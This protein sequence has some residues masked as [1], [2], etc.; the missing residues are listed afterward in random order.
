VLKDYKRALY[1]ANARLDI[2]T[3]L[4]GQK[5]KRAIDARIYLGNVYGHA[6]E[7]DRAL[8]VFFGIAKDIENTPE[9]N[10]YKLV[11]I[12]DKTTFLYE[13]KFDFSAALTWYKKSLNA[14]SDLGTIRARLDEEN[15]ERYFPFY[16]Y[17]YEGA[18]AFEV[19]LYMYNK[20]RLTLERSRG[21]KHEETANCYYSIG[22]MYKE[23]EKYSEA[24]GWFQKS[25]DIRRELLGED[26]P[27]TILSKYEVQF[28][29]EKLQKTEK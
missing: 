26:H 9:L 2:D 22:G 21:V 25:F 20:S 23:F 1:Y 28:C 17:S 14:E 11:Y 24:L 10:N 13:M 7:P 5:D 15:T 29:K 16:K 19:E 8:E 18:L 27:S 3:S 12:Y 4:W 6:M